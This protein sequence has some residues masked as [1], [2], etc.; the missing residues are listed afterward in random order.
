MG[1]T[2]IRT[3][4]CSSPAALLISGAC[5]LMA[6]RARAQVRDE[7]LK[8]A[9]ARRRRATAAADGGVPGKL[10]LD[11]SPGLSIVAEDFSV[12][13]AI[14]NFPGLRRSKCRAV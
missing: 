9:G 10:V 8:G 11:E 13:T 1:S 14:F 5:Y 3:S 7:P 12:Y 4:S 2:T 6:Q